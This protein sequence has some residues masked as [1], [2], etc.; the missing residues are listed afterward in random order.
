[1]SKL[2]QIEYAIPDEGFTLDITGQKTS[3]YKWTPLAVDAGQIGSIE[4]HNVGEPCSAVYL[5]GQKPDKDG[6]MSGRIVKGDWL[7]LM[8]RV[9]EAR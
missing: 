9:N 8:Q 5:L 1:M 4:P 6:R 3:G 2:I 7:E